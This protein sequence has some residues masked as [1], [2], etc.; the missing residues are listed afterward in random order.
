[1]IKY[2][3]NG[4]LYEKK[5]FAIY[6]INMCNGSNHDCDKCSYISVINEGVAPART[7]GWSMQF[8]EKFNFKL[9]D[10]YKEPPYML[11]SLPHT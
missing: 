1:M 5:S 6:Y 7:G 3:W 8:C 10:S 4:D 9:G 11:G 2:F